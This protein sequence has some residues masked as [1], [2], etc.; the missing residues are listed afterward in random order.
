MSER[1]L[2]AEIVRSGKWLYDGAVP[3]EVWIVRQNFEY[4]F[5]EEYS[6]EP[7][8]LNQDGEIFQVVFARD[9]QFMSLGPDEL[10]IE[11]AAAGAES[12]LEGKVEWTDHRNSKLFG[13]RRYS[14]V[15]V[16]E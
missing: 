4:W 2:R 11:A 7:E 10:L 8:K 1:E 12:I 9:G 5:E 16:D 3:F 15:P 13:G 14:I 6:D